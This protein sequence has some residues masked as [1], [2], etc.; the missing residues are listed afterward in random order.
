[1]KFFSKYITQDQVLG[2]SYRS[3]VPQQHFPAAPSQLLCVLRPNKTSF[4]CFSRSNTWL[5][6]IGYATSRRRLK[7]PDQMP[8]PVRWPP[9]VSPLSLSGQISK[10]LPY[11]DWNVDGLETSWASN[12]EVQQHHCWHKTEAAKHLTLTCE[13]GPAN[14]EL[15]C[16]GSDF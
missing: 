13:Q 5:R 3:P 9:Y 16:W 10:I 4:Q 15:T 2:E 7:P 8:K 6:T 12:R 14:L 1:M 11:E